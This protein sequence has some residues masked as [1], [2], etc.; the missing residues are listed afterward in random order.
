METRRLLD[1]VAITAVYALLPLAV[2]TPPT[3]WGTYLLV[4]V[5]AIAYAQVFV[6]HRLLR[7]AAG[8]VYIESTVVW[9]QQRYALDL[10]VRAVHEVKPDLDPC[11]LEADALFKALVKEVEGS[12]EREEEK[13]GKA[14]G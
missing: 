5:N 7:A 13:E 9:A 10:P 2:L 4:S 6:R 8:I 3:V 11:A 14:R 12:G 1:T